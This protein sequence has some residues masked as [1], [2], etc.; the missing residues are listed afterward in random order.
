MKDVR[1]KIDL[2]G[3]QQIVIGYGIGN[4]ILYICEDN[5]VWLVPS[6]IK[7][8]EFYEINKRVINLGR[9]QKRITNPTQYL[10]TISNMLQSITLF[11]YLVD[12]SFAFNVDFDFNLTKEI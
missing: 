4:N 5:L 7:Q 3:E 8:N 6:T 9:V 10:N 2:D 12:E 1:L 11:D